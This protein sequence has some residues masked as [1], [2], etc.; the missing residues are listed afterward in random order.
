MSYFPGPIRHGPRCN[1]TCKK[2]KKTHVLSFGFVLGFG[3]S[4][5][6]FCLVVWACGLEFA[7]PCALLFMCVCS[8]VLVC[9]RIKPACDVSCPVLPCLVLPS[10]VASCPVFPYIVVLFVCFILFLQIKAHSPASVSPRLIPSPQPWQYELAKRKL[11]RDGH[12]PFWAFCPHT[13]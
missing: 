9:H 5:S 2:T 13:T 11:S 3:H 1:V 12:L 7:R 6:M 10:L 4:C 8:P